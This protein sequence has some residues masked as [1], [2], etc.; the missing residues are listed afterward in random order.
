MRVTNS[1]MVRNM[2]DHLQNNL[3]DLNDL[4]EQLSS[5]KLFQMPSDAPIKVADSMNYKSQLNRNNQ[6]QRNLNQTENWLNTTE[7]ALKS[8]TEVI[9]RARELTIYAANDS[10]TS[11]DRK[12]VAKEMKQLRDELIDISNAKLGDSYIFSGQKTGEKPFIL[13]SDKTDI[14]NYVDYQGDKNSVKRRLNE[15]VE[16]GVNLNGHEVFK[17]KIDKLNKIYRQ[18]ENNIPGKDIKGEDLSDNLDEM[19]DFINDYAELRSQVGGKLQRTG[20]I[21]DRLEANEVHLRTLK[22]K[23]E[24]ADLAEVITELKMEETVYRASLASGSRIM[25]QSLVDFIR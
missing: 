16:M 10:M 4:N 25:Q 17:D 2:L 20:N 21:I 13:N 11:D 19:D 14:D 3:G 8:G 5:G 23:N 6:F 1:M 15:N 7:S 22:S 9:Q 12:M 24:D 18:L